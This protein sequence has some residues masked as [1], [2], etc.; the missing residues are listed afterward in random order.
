MPSTDISSTCRM[1]LLCCQPGWLGGAVA[2]DDASAVPPSTTAA[3]A[4]TAPPRQNSFL[5]M[6]YH[7][8][9]GVVS[10]QR[11]P[12][13]SL[14]KVTSGWPRAEQQMTPFRKFSA[15]GQKACNF[16]SATS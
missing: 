7:S 14:P 11:S 13:P 1:L 2:A 16:L 9:S 15:S 12:S 10:R 5:R 4:T 3:L 6:V 8:L